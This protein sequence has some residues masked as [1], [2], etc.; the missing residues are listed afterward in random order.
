MDDVVC[1][2]SGEELEIEEDVI[3]VFEAVSLGVEDIGCTKLV[4]IQ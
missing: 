3:E 2:S 1:L 4:I